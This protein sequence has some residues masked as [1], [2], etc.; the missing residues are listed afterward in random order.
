MSLLKGLY[1]ETFPNQSWHSMENL[2]IVWNALGK[3]CNR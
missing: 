3:L 1:N 2:G